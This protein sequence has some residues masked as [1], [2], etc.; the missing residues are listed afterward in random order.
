MRTA[1]SVDRAAYTFCLLEQFHRHIKH[2]NV[3]VESSSKWRD[4]RAHLLTGA[5][6][7]AAR[8]AGLNALGLPV[9]P[10]GMLADHVTV[11]D[12]AYREVAARLDADTP[13]T[14]DDEGKLHAAALVAV[15]DP[16]S[17]RLDRGAHSAASHRPHRGSD[18]FRRARIS[19]HTPY[20]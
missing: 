7:E 3:F 1:A 8:E 4:P 2:R 5:S 15:P 18:I 20:L 6:W 10:A 16:P 14:V 13:A 12:A 17:P 11:F 19:F 9:E